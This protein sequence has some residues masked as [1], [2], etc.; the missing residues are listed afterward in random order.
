MC[1]NK[2]T[3]KNWIV[4][5]RISSSVSA[6]ILV[7]YIRGHGMQYTTSELF[8]FFS[9]S[10]FLGWILES[11]YRTISDHHW[12]NAGFLFGPFVPIYGIGA[13][14]IAGLSLA[15][16]DTPG[17]LFW[18]V[19][20]SS[21]TILEYAASFLLEKAFSLRLWDYSKKRF[22]LHGRVCLFTSGIWAI[23]SLIAAL[24]INPFLI[25]EIDGLTLMN[26]YFIFGALFMYFLI[27]EI[28]SINSIIGFKKFIR[29]L[30]E[31]IKR[32]IVFI[33]SSD[34]GIGR[35]P[36]EF[37]HIIKPLKSHPH[38]ASVLKPMLQVIPEP[39]ANKLISTVGTRHF[40]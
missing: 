16:K 39:I 10:A 29:D 3:D 5:L 31:H 37:R 24:L 40:K 8:L 32:G 25:S 22:N 6:G 18:P 38:L 2:Q 30:S 27:D 35:V 1:V 23:L 34:L 28:L 36:V 12:V 11:S 17:F 9:V 19:L 33:P 26:Q 21:P 20:M 7:A 4:M 15:M 14:T 13:M